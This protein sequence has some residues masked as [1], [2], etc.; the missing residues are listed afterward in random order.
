MFCKNC[1]NEIEDGSKF[2][3][4]CGTLQDAPEV[5]GI[6]SSEEPTIHQQAYNSGTENSPLTSESETEGTAHQIIG[7]EYIFKIP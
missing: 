2:C 1:G 5:S 3:G 7:R 6:S 4:K